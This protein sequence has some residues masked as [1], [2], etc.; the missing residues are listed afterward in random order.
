M[1]AQKLGHPVPDSNL[2]SASNSAVPQQEQRKIPLSCRSQY[3]PVKARSVPSWRVIS[4]ACGESCCFHWSSV[5][6]TLGRV[7]DSWR[8]PESENSTMVTFSGTLVVWASGT[9]VFLI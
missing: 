2:V 6:T 8:S 7:A 1:G 5:L 3:S 4:K 9:S